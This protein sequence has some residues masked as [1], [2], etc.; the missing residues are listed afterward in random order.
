[1]TLRNVRMTKVFQMM[2][3][4]FFLLAC[5]TTA[6]VGQDAAA[7]LAEKQLDQE[8][9]ELREGLVDGFKRRDI[10]AMLAYVTPDIIVTWQNAE[11]SHGKD[12]LRTF[13]EQMMVGPDSVVSEVDGSPTIEGR[14]IYDNQIISY[15]HMNDRF[16]LRATGETLPFDSRFSALVVRNEGRLALSGLHLSVN[17]FDNAIMAAHVGLYK[18]VA[19]VGSIVALLIG[20]FLGRRLAK[21][22]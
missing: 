4:V 19:I 18:N 3:S 10:S 8:L 11:I 7:P 15:G 1:M 16:T 6:S 12:E 2:M 9:S 17:A 13:I 5:S 14:K 20:I 21:R 22:T